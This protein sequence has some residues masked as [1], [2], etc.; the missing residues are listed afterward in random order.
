MSRF[1]KHACGD[2]LVASQARFGEAGLEVAVEGVEAGGL[3]ADIQLLAAGRIELSARAVGKH[4][5]ICI[6]VERAEQAGIVLLRGA[7]V[8][9]GDEVFAQH[10][11]LCVERHAGIVAQIAV[12]IARPFH[13]IGHAARADG[14]FGQTDNRPFD[15]TRHDPCVEL[16]FAGDLAIV[17]AEIELQRS[18]DHRRGEFDKGDAIVPC[19]RPPGG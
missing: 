18:A 13:V 12:E 1:G 19:H 15:V 9:D 6:G 8:S 17:E 5:V 2:P 3:D 4:C 10:A 16:L 7:V 14:A 11:A